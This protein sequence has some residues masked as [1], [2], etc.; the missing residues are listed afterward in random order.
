MDEKQYAE[1]TREYN[2]VYIEFI[3]L[4]VKISLLEMVVQALLYIYTIFFFWPKVARVKKREFKPHF[5]HKNWPY[6]FAVSRYSWRTLYSDNYSI[7]LLTIVALSFL[8]FS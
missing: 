2:F 6:R 3:D 7:S 8:R 5:E 1:S 4:C